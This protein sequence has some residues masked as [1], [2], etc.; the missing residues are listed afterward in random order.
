[1]SFQKANEEKAFHLLTCN[2]KGCIGCIQII[3][4]FLTFDYEYITD[5]NELAYNRLQQMNN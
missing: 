4:L 5:L 2:R 1:M 3:S